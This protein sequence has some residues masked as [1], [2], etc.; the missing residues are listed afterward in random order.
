MEN[1][2]I[3]ESSDESKPQSIY[4]K[5]MID[6]FDF[7]DEGASLSPE[8]QSFISII[9]NPDGAILRVGKI[10]QI[11]P[12]GK[13]FEHGFNELKKCKIQW[14]RKLIERLD[15]EIASND[16]SAWFRGQSKLIKSRILDII[17][18]KER[19]K[20]ETGNGS[21]QGAS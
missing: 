5:I 4:K 20:I 12:I 6:A 8:N 11:F 16:P 9:V 14:L 17:K 15:Q 21:T 2:L 7:E 1:Q 13:Q 18:E 10:E 19:E 3:S